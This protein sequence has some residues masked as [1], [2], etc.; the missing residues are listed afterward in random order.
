MHQCTIFPWIHSGNV[1]DIFIATSIFWDRCGEK[2]IQINHIY[3][4]LP[5]M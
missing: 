3:K 2:N 1:G 4:N 5:S